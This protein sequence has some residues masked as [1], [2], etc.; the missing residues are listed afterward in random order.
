MA[1]GFLGTLTSKA[2]MTALKDNA[3]GSG[4]GAIASLA[5]EAGVER[6]AGVGPFKKLPAPA[7]PIAEALTGA[8]A[9][10]LIAMKYPMVGLG[11]GMVLTATGLTRTAKMFAP[12]GLLPASATAPTTAGYMGAPSQDSLLLGDS[13][14]EVENV[15]PELGDSAVEIETV[16][17]PYHAVGAFVY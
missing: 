5:W 3:I 16:E 10:P 11:V 14:Q 6:L 4:A 12:K 15:R 13:S 8:V 1:R 7:F 17:E 2:Y 9:G